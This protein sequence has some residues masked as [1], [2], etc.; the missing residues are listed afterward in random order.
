MFGVEAFAGSLSQ[1]AGAINLASTAF[2]VFGSLY[3]GNQ[4]GELAD[5]EAAKAGEQARVER[6]VGTVRAARTRKIGERQAGT[7]RAGY[8]GSGVDVS[9]GSAAVV[10]GELSSR[11]E[12]DALTEILTGARRGRALEISADEKRRAAA[13]ARMGGLWNAGSSLLGGF[14]RQSQIS[15]WGGRV[16]A[17]SMPSAGGGWIDAGTVGFGDVG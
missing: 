3:R 8:A 11:I 16:T 7:V 15:K 5:Y 1:Y 4:E 10:A 9:S 6:E 12:L 13:N 14:A 17:T 2:N